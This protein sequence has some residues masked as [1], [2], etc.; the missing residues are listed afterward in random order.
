MDLRGLIFVFLLATLAFGQIFFFLLGNKDCSGDDQGNSELFET[1]TAAACPPLRSYYLRAMALSF[2]SSDLQEQEYNNAFFGLLFVIFTISI[3][4]ILFNACIAVAIDSHSR[5]VEHSHKSGGRGRLAYLA[6]LFAVQNLLGGNWTLMQYCAATLFS[7]SVVVLFILSIDSIRKDVEDQY[8]NKALIANAVV[9]LILLLI[10]VIAFL[11]HINFQTTPRRIDARPSCLS[12][13]CN[14]KIV[15][16][17]ASPAKLCVRKM[18]SLDDERRPELDIPKWNGRWAKMRT[19]VGHLG[20]KNT[21]ALKGDIH[22]LISS[23]E[24]NQR[25][26]EE[27]NRLDVLTQM[28]ASEGRIQALIEDFHQVLATSQKAH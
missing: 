18:L 19:E 12:K 14:H 9:L 1:N 2:G 28:R 10:S 21:T 11:A 4:M 13:L 3:T 16:W 6:D 17:A 24:R 20:Q 5:W 23:M 15:S 26:H 25:Q 27:R 22:E 7:T 8:G